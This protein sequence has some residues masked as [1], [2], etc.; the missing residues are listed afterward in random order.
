[1]ERIKKAGAKFDIEKAKWFNQQYLQKKTDAELSNTYDD[2]NDR[3]QFEI[4]NYSEKLNELI[5]INA[6]I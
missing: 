1:M 6:K 3:L 2:V 5:I 4:Q